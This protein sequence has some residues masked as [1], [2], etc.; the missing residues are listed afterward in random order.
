LLQR[1]LL[2]TPRQKP[3]WPKGGFTHQR[4]NSGGCSGHAIQE[5]CYFRAFLL[6][7]FEHSLEFGERRDCGVT[8]ISRTVVKQCGRLN[9]LD[10]SVYGNQV[11]HR[12]MRPGPH[13]GREGPYVVPLAG[14][15]AFR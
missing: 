4:A 9:I 5:V 12:M 1:H 8:G 13:S 10:Q 7:S 2:P 14:F 6:Q 11:H 15:L 3:H